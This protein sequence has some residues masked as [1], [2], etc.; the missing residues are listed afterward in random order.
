MAASSVNAPQ[1]Q[2]VAVGSVAPAALTYGYQSVTATTGATT[3]VTVPA[4]QT[5]MGTLTASVA[6]SAAAAATTG[7][8]AVA[9]F[10]TAGTGVAPAAG[11]YYAVSCQVGAN[12]AA[13]TAGSA[14]QNAGSLVNFVV[15]APAANAVQV[16][17]TTTIVGS[18]RID[19]SAIGTLL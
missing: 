16:Q 13:G 14:C 8:S 19:S 6:A 9:A 5:W 10:S 3:L 15:V 4:G 12:T 17:V 7:A 2:P 11:T 1:V 18:G